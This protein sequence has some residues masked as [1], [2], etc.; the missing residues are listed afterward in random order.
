MWAS[1]CMRLEDAH[2]RGDEEVP[3]FGRKYVVNMKVGQASCAYFPTRHGEHA[4]LDCGYRLSFI[5]GI[6]LPDCSRNVY[7]FEHA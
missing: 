4:S 2:Q 3:V 7:P 1:D 5:A 6:V